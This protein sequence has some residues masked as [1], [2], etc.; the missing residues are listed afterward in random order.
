M[1]RIIKNILSILTLAGTLNTT[2]AQTVSPNYQIIHNYRIYSDVSHPNIFYYEPAS[3]RLSRDENGKPELHLLKM[4]Y[5]GSKAM[6]DE[7]KIRFH[8]TLQFKIIADNSDAEGW[9]I[10]K[11]ALKKNTPNSILLPLPIT[12]FES[13]LVY[14]VVQNEDSSLRILKSGFMEN[15]KDVSNVNASY[16]TERNF[17]IRLSNADAQ[18]L[19][20]AINNKQSIIS[21]SYAFYAAFAGRTGSGFKGN[22]S[23]RLNKNVIQYLDSQSRA[24]NDSSVKKLLVKA[25]VVD[26][27]VESGKWNDII[28]EIEMDENLS[29]SYPLLDVYCYDFNN[30]IRPDLFCKKIEIEA[31]AFNGKKVTVFANF[32]QT[33]PDQF[34]KSIRF[35]YAV[36]YDRPFRFRVTEVDINGE[37]KISEWKSVSSWN[38]IIDVTT[39]KTS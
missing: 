3:F 25:D 26:L 10:V 30:G 32:R 31:I 18:L 4:R 1:N 6:N 39:Q 23:D 15:V 27:S 38:E 29:F 7:G 36:R 19:E 28:E 22:T 5:T 8:N 20:T 14:T 11:S 9:Q 24:Q 17:S 13:L 33:Q 35:P 34:A 16:W 37:S 2:G 12:K 21:M